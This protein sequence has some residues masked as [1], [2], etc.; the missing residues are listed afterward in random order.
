MEG[1]GARTAD[2]ENLGKIASASFPLLC[3]L[4]FSTEMYLMRNSV[5][6]SKSSHMPGLDDGTFKV[7]TPLIKLISFRRSM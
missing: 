4:T 3:S 1:G 2:G 6:L 7:T 5:Y